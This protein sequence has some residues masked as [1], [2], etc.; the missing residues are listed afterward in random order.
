M[1]KFDVF[2][3][4]NWD[5]K[6]SVK[7]L[8]NELTRTY[9]LRV[10]MDEYE[11]G[12]TRLVDELSKAIHNSQVFL[13]CITKKYS[14]SENCKDEI[15]Y[16]KSLKK[17]MVVLMFD[18]LTMDELGGVGFIIGPKVRFNCYKNP[19]ML[20]TWRDDSMFDSIISAIKEHIATDSSSGSDTLLG[21]GT[22]ETENTLV[23]TSRNYFAVVQQDGNFVLYK[24]NSLKRE[25][26]LWA[27]NTHG[28]RNARPYTLKLLNNGNL[29]L[30]DANNGE[31]WSTNSA[32]KGQPGSYKLVM[33]N[34]GN[35]VLYDS[36]M[37][38]IWATNT[39][40]N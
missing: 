12:Q 22:L 20:R 9:S 14:E 33:Q 15:D 36:K 25:N 34:D 4:Y 13:C 10:W 2:I 35:L 16:A 40:N 19:N 28:S 39:W 7:A 21:N 17:P 37:T 1:A 29:V 23:S 38:A 31:V 18:R 8:Y 32:G 24:S 5:V 27:S 3:S 30:F 26:P 11:L 6:D